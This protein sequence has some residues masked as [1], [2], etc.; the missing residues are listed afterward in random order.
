VLEA[1]GL[2]DGGAVP[3]RRPRLRNISLKVRAGEVVGL[4][5]LVGAGRTELAL[6]LFGARSGVT[7]KVR[8]AG[9]PVALRSPADAIA[10]GIG[11]P[12][13]DRKEAGLFPEMSI[14]DNISAVAA[15]R[16]GSWW[17]SRRR[18]RAEVLDLCRALRVVCRGPTEVVQNLSG[19]NQQKVVLARWLLAR[20]RVLIV[21]E[22]TRGVDV[23]AK[24]EIH[25]LLY[26]LAREGTAVVVISS[27][28]PEIL[29]VSDRVVVL[30]EGRITGELP[31]GRATEPA[32]M[33]LAS[34][35]EGGR[36]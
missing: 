26:A 27:D 8:I 14:E 17:Y 10:A 20:P 34:L 2:S 15:R 36:P 21:D 28:L 16:F 5:G 6:A 23:R 4:A 25:T 19:G 29:A 11:Y 3:G 1:V 33:H 22:P 31:R 7:G 9:R 30:R 12:P 13:E 18:Q 32:V 35:G 24:A